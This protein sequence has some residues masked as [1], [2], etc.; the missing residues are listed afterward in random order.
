M[1]WVIDETPH[2]NRSRLSFGDIEA[3]TQRLFSG[4]RT[5]VM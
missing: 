4:G 1:Q 5:A 2:A 3:P